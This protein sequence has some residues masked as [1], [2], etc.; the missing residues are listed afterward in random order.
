[1]LAAVTVSFDILVVV[2]RSSGGKGP[3][4]ENNF[5]QKHWEDTNVQACERGPQVCSCLGVWLV[6]VECDAA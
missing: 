1:M 4:E 5:P 2:E 6:T 3:F